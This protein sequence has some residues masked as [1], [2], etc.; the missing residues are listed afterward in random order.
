[1]SENKTPNK[2]WGLAFP[3]GDGRGVDGDGGVDGSLGR[4][5]REEMRTGK[6]VSM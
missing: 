2:N 1:M 3:N 4:G 5:E 6:L